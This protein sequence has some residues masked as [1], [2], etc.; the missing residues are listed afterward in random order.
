MISFR[1][2]RNPNLI[3]KRACKDPCIPVRCATWCYERPRIKPRRTVRDTA[4]KIHSV[5]DD[6]ASDS[7]SGSFATVT[8]PWVF[9]FIGGYNRR[10]G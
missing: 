6:P 8:E 3:H 1:E 2:G 5:V 9:A 4:S 7:S 10:A